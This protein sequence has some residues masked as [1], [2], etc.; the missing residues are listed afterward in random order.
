MSSSASV[1]YSSSSAIRILQTNAFT[2]TL[3]PAP[4]RRSRAHQHPSPSLAVV[5]AVEVPGALLQPRHPG[6]QAEPA[7]LLGL[8]V[9]LQHGVSRER[10][11]V[12]AL[13]RQRGDLRAQWITR[14]QRGL[15]RARVGIY[16]RSSPPQ[17]SR[18]VER[19]EG[20]PG[21]GPAGSPFPPAPSPCTTAARCSRCRA[22]VGQRYEHQHRGTVRSSEE[23]DRRQAL[24]IVVVVTG[25]RRPATRTCRAFRT[26]R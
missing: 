4:N 24:I 18:N 9:E 23:Q 20:V 15:A 3:S 7:P 6:G 14:G 1:A 25:R 22:A 17:A 12:A 19:E 26:R 2:F 11:G 8:L 13:P 16:N 5:R 21:R 10:A